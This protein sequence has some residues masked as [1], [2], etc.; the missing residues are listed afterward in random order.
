[1]RAVWGG[2][3]VA[4]LLVLVSALRADDQADAKAL[5]DKSLKAMGGAEKVA[6]LKT[7]TCKAKVTHEDN[8]RQGTILCEV[9]WQGMDKARLDGELSEGG[10][11][12]KVFFVINGDTG[13]EK[14]ND[15]ARDA[16][17][18]LVSA[19][20]NAFH[21]LRMPYLLPDLKG[22]AFKLSLLGE[23]KVND[24]AAVGLSVS[25]KDYKDVNVY[26]D[27]ET[28]L[29]VKSEIRVIDP[30]GKEITIE[31]FYN[32]FQ[33]VEGIKHPMKI[34]M[35]ADGKDFAVE[36]TEVKAKDKVD[37]SEFAKP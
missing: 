3:F 32:D 31:Y 6:K 12:H 21:A 19:I 9:T 10:Q 30:E 7:G 24:K 34:S 28:G 11:T 16:P 13:W 1:M 14:K 20:K 18:N 36:I 35:K 4:C 2:S 17:A 23:V 5:I 25:H 27:K 15:T 26:F 37:E 8:G 33:A 29:P 22:T